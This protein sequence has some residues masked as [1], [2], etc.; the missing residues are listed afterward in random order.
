MYDKWVSFRHDNNVN[1]F[2]ELI[3]LKDK[4][5][6]VSTYVMLKHSI[7]ILKMKD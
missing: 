1:A 4:S 7:A 3:E 2:Y 5:I 6:K